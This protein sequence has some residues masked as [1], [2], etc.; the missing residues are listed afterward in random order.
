MGACTSLS[1]GQKEDDHTRTQHSRTRSHAVW[2]RESAQIYEL[3]SYSTHPPPPEL[4]NS[5]RHNNQ[6]DG[7]GGAEYL[8]GRSVNNTSIRVKRRGTTLDDSDSTDSMASV[9]SCSSGM[10]DQVQPLPMGS[11]IEIPGTILPGFIHRMLWELCRDLCFRKHLTYRHIHLHVWNFPKI[12]EHRTPMTTTSSPT[13]VSTTS[14]KKSPRV[15][16]S[17]SATAAEIPA[18]ILQIRF[19]SKMSLEDQQSIASFA[20]NQLEQRFANNKHWRSFSFGQFVERETR[21]NRHFNGEVQSMMRQLEKALDCWIHL[22]D[23]L[24]RV[25]VY[26]SSSKLLDTTCH[27]VAKTLEYIYL[28][29]HEEHVGVSTELFQALKARM[30]LSDKS[31]PLSVPAWRIWLGV[32]RENVLDM[33]SKT[34]CNKDDIVSSST[35]QSESSSSLQDDIITVPS[36]CSTATKECVERSA[37]SA[38]MD[39]R[40][41]KHNRSTTITTGAKCGP[42]NWR[43]IGTWLVIR[44]DTTR[45]DVVIYSNSLLCISVAKQQVAALLDELNRMDRSDEVQDD[46]EAGYSPAV[47]SPRVHAQLLALSHHYK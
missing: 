18:P 12:E 9:S 20:T 26:V 16:S 42:K 47:V 15:P 36:S 22:D 35:A 11:F 44:L 32:I 40:T 38:P 2:E 27:R 14:P 25:H 3:T 23:G 41:V 4:L 34:N 19:C 39:V 30:T 33:F 29:R 8:G 7:G 21:P 31:T 46:V 5:C 37:S 17:S 28:T 10:S 13:V 43:T 24:G 6:Q 45:R 1:S